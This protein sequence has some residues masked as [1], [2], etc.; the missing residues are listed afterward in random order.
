MFEIE[1]NKGYLKILNDLQFK[2]LSSYKFLP[3]EIIFQILESPGNYEETY[4]QYLDNNFIVEPNEKRENTLI[5]HFSLE[6]M[7]IGNMPYFMLTLKD[8]DFSDHPKSSPSIKK[9]NKKSQ[10]KIKKELI[11]KRKLGLTPLLESV[12]RKLDSSINN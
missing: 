11:M 2:L 6:L 5:L 10:E 4:H 7:N 9:K 12:T 8:E 1:N 3:K